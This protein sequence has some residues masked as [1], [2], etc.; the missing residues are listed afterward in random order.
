MG[1]KLSEIIEVL[2]QRKDATNGENADEFTVNTAVNFVTLNQN[3]NHLMDAANG[4]HKFVAGDQLK[5]ISMAYTLL[6][7]FKLW[8]ISDPRTAI[9]IQ[10]E[11]IDSVNG[12]ESVVFETQTIPW[13]NYEMQL[14]TV[15]FID[16]TVFSSGK[17]DLY[18]R[19]QG[20]ADININMIEPA[21]AYNALVFHM[22][23]WIKILHTLPLT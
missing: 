19:F 4:M 10:L 1:V 21:A 8:E 14:G 20:E 5:F 12:G 18:A 13:A 3:G 17:F 7:P 15:E 23:I 2:R 6:Y 16:P 22:P 9:Q 11:A